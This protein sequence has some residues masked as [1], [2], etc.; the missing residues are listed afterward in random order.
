MDIWN[1]HHKRIHNYSIYFLRDHPVEIVHWSHND[2][3]FLKYYHF[4]EYK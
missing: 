4:Y 1:Q 2:F 3:I